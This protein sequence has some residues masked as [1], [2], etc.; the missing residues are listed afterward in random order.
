MML[1]ALYTKLQVSVKLN[2]LLHTS[3]AKK[4]FSSEWVL[5]SG[6]NS[7]WVLS[8]GENYVASSFYNWI[9]G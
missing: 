9:A 2:L 6:E 7:E 5:P 3:C 8:S 4:V 1:I